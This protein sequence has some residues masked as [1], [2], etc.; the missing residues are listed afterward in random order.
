MRTG[1]KLLTAMRATAM[2]ATMSA[3]VTGSKLL[4]AMRGTCVVEGAS[5]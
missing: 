4:T 2:V 3:G 5:A 1:S